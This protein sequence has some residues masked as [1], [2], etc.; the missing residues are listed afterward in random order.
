MMYVKLVLKS[1]PFLLFF[2][3]STQVLHGQSTVRINEF[4]ASNTGTINDPDFNESADWIELFNA[5]P[6]TIDLSGYFLTDDLTNASKWTIPNG[7]SLP[8]G[9]YLLIWADGENTGLHTNF[10]LSSAGEEIGLFD[11]AGTPVD[12]VIFKEQ[13]ANISFG[14]LNN[15]ASVWRYLESPTPG[16]VNDA[17]G[18]LGFTQPVSFSSAGGFYSGALSVTLSTTDPA[19]TI[20]YTLD[21]AAPTELSSAYTGALTI[22]ETQVVRATVF[23][24][25][26][27]TSPIVS[28][29][30]LVNENTE[31]PVVS[32]ALDPDHLWSDEKGMYVAG[33]NGITGNCEAEPRNWNQDWEYAASMEFF[34]T[35]QTPT[36]NQVVGLRIF[37]GCSRLYDQKSLSVHARNRY[38]KGKIKHKFFQGDEPDE[39]DSLTLRNSGQD[40]FRTMMRD[41]MI[42]SVISKGIEIDNLAYR[43]AILFLN[44]EYFG[45]HNIREKMNADYIK[46]KHGYE[47]DEIDFLEFDGFVLRG[48]NNHYNAMINFVSSNDMSSNQN[49]AFVSTLMDIDHYLDYVSAEIYIANADWPSGNNKFWRP[50]TSNG[51]WRWM[52][53]DTDLSF[54]GN[55]EGKFFSNTVVQ[56][57]EPNGPVWPNPPWSTLLFRSLLENQQ[58]QHQFIQRIASHTNITFDSTYVHHVIDSLQTQIASEIPRHKERWTESIGFNTPW[59]VH[60]ER[61]IEFPVERP[62][63]LRTHLMDHFNLSGLATLQIQTNMPE[64]GKVFV[65]DVALRSA[66]FSG[67]YF[68]QIPIELR[69]EAL[70]GYKFAGWEGGLVSNADSVEIQISSLTNITANF[71]LAEPV[72][73]EPLDSSY[74]FALK[75][76]Y[77]NPVSS[78]TTIPYEVA[79]SVQVSLKVYDLLGREVQTLLNKQVPAGQHQLQLNASGLAAGVYIYELSAGAFTDRKKFIVTR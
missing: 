19:G 29:T 73:I 40:W 20:R 63:H 24:A 1:L 28:Q 2:C 66:D 3:I 62:A 12:A 17:N 54:G 14:L 35:D 30:Y 50:K 41:G 18:F 44:G 75:Q 58:F 57:T 25:G 56:A 4:M 31:L 47:E 68:Q 43:P 9:A 11:A 15:N 53:F 64:G 34:E 79:N 37:G 8:S 38:G 48:D 42:Q 67:E 60:L 77:P 72:D 74:R 6:S 36:I 39:F 13:T 61:L 5:G 21:G 27:L 59:P 76:N 10:K 65:S 16:A 26:Y 45:I 46:N 22:N 69:A 33:T 7:T 23:R 32:I 71:D 78:L 51:K 49:L 52:L 55:A 70:P